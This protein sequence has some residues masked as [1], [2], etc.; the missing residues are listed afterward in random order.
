MELEKEYRFKINENI[1]EKITNIS[2]LV[3]P[4]QNQIDLTLGY[5]GFDSLDIYGYVC[6]VRKKGEKIWIEVKNKKSDGI[7]EE[8]KINIESFRKGVDLFEAL[9]MKPYLFMNR[10]RTILKYKGLK[11]FIDRIDMLGDYVEIEVQ[12]SKNPE[13]EY[14]EFIYLTGI[15]S[16][17]EPLY[18]DIFKEKLRDKEFNCIFQRR[19]KKSLEE[20]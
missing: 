20:I 3:E 11:I 1:I 17:P 7:F 5:K 19:L 2:E 9:N 16:K 4:S 12:D 15:N 8:T 10:T 14:N 6:R 13:E 18:G